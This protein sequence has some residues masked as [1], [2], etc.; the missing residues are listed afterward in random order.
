MTPVEPPQPN[1]HASAQPQQ[2]QPSGARPQQVLSSGTL[3]D[4]ERSDQ[5]TTSY[6]HS[7]KPS[8]EEASDAPGSVSCPPGE[9]LREPAYQA[10]RLMKFAHGAM[11]AHLRCR[12]PIG[13]SRHG[14]SGEAA[15]TRY[16]A[17]T[18]WLPGA[19]V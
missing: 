7:R 4:G 14:D 10:V 1:G 9:R 15:H 18:D 8:E 19:N 12:R 11:C 13:G 6:R 16:A 5:G 17:P 2:A 3:S